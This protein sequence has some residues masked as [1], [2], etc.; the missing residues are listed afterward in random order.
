MLIITPKV[1]ALKHILALNIKSNKNLKTNVMQKCY[2]VN[3]L[4][5][6]TTDDTLMLKVVQE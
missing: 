3:A 1:C 4:F 5:S 2:K 6:K